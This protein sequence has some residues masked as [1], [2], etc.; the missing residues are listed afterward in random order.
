M[1]SG[2]GTSAI[3]GFEGHGVTVGGNS[4]GVYV[5][6]GLMNTQFGIGVAYTFQ[7]WLELGCWNTANQLVN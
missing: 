7:G 4:S 1:I 3:A 5:G 2:W 6:E